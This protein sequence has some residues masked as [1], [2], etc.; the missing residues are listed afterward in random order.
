LAVI[1]SRIDDSVMLTLMTALVPALF[2][3]GRFVTVGTFTA[4]GLVETS[5]V[6]MF[7]SFVEETFLTMT[8]VRLVTLWI[9]KFQLE[10]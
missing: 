9:Q 3:E 10:S 7:V 4:E 6:T 1:I 8:T 2:A 5:F